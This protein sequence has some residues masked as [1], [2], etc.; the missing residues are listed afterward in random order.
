MLV[1]IKSAPDTPEGRRGVRLARDMSADIILLQNGVYFIQGR[2]LEELG[3][4]RDTY[5]LEDD[6]KLRGLKQA[7]ADKNIKGIGYDELVDL[8]AES[9]KVI[10]LF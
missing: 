1:L 8:M 6:R 9:D 7:G 10:G 2:K 3:V 5:V 4:Y